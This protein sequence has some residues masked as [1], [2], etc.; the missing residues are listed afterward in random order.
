MNYRDITDLNGDTRLF[1]QELPIDVDL[2]VGIPRSGLLVANYLSLY[3]DVPMTDVDGLCN[4]TVFDTGNRFPEDFSF[5]QLDSVIVVDDSVLS[6]NQMTETR[7]RLDAHEIPFD[8]SYAAVYVSSW[9]HR[10][11]DYWGEVVPVP[12]VFE[13]NLLHH[14]LLKNFCVDIDGVLCR[15]PTPEENDDGENYRQFL[16]EVEPNIVPN[17]PIGWLVTSRLEQYRPETEA[18]L[19][20]H[21]I[22]YDRLVMLDLPD[23]EAR[24]E[25]GQYAQYKAEVYDETGADLF[26]ES[27]P[28]QAV[29]ISELT[30]K[31]VFCYDTYEMIQPGG[32]GRAYQKSASI[33]SKF[34]A[35]PV[36]F[37]GFL[38]KRFLYRCH[39][40][41]GN[42]ALVSSRS[43]RSDQE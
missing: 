34:S 42:N 18:W 17:Q 11:V 1:A 13:W 40:L 28:E 2:V 39:H 16:S 30:N 25:L 6:G 19:D 15:N 35:D 43:G 21:G 24:Q 20:R 3:L 26:I 29:E 31:P 4:G 9:G 37:T 10:Y 22:E 41:I 23:Q 14:S 5:E 38:G 12:R 27:E 7:S 8:I 36:G 32:V 33:L